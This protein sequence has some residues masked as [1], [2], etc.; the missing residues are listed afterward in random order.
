MQSQYD[1]EGEA[2]A[3][4]NVV[5]ERSLISKEVDEL[6]DSVHAAVKARI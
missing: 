2:N 3:K 4:K 1:R 6:L 5:P